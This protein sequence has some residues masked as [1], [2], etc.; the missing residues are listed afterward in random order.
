MS[1]TAGLDWRKSTFSNGGG[2]ECVEI[3]TTPDGGR[4]VRDTK[5][6]GNGPI[7]RFTAAEWTAFTRGVKAGEFDH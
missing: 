5:D 7:L 3:A 4:A 2:G 6:L 1:D